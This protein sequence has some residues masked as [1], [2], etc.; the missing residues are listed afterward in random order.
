MCNV[1]VIPQLSQM[2]MDSDLVKY[3]VDEHLALVPCLEI[4]VK[5]SKEDMECPQQDIPR[6]SFSSIC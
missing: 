5:L 3:S 6:Y 4:C 2:Q 1:V